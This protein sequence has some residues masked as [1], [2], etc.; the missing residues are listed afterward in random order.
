MATLA[1][2]LRAGYQPPKESALGDPIVQHFRDLPENLEKNQRAMDK[3]MG[4]MYKTDWMGKPNPNYYPEA[5][6]EFTQNYMPNLM[7]VHVPHTP[8]K[9]GLDVGKR[10][11]TE[12][13]GNLA[14][15]AKLKFEDL[16]GSS[17]LIMPWDSTSRNIAIKEI[18]GEKLPRQVVTHGGQDY[19][20]DLAHQAEGVV[21]ASNLG[22]AKRI[23]DR[24][25]MA[26]IE[27]ERMGGTGQVI[28][29]PTTMGAGAENFSV[30]PTEALLSLV[31]LRNP[32]KSFY[33][34]MNNAIR[35]TSPEGKPLSFKP[36]KGFAGID[37]EIGR[38][39]LYNG[40]GIDSTAGELRKAL[41]KALSKKSQGYNGGNTQQY[42]NYNHEDLVNA[43]T[44]PDLLGVGKG[45][46]GNTII[47]V[48]PEGMH[49][50]PSQNPT[51]NTNFT[52]Q[53]LGTLGENVPVE[54]IFPKTFRNLEQEFAGK[55][56]S[57][58]NNVLGA[59]EKRKMGVS[60]F[61]DDE[62]IDNY[63]KYLQD[64]KRQLE[65]E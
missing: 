18:S 48:G 58:R 46:V 11:V 7:G 62:A 49:L 15:K 28:H 24:D 8:L 31:D 56:G 14:D 9:P 39:Q 40:E 12:E 57:M 25:A 29:L 21:G 41:V 53:Y 33:D 47:G 2:L 38:M 4:G 36:F 44:D 13:L 34:Q 43:L 1:D 27:N 55:T 59:M 16:K 5:M 37:S 51:Y 61:I 30:M 10:Y 54:A 3:T 35:N 6:G 64:R 65:Q 42:L 23:K 32:S 63:Y 45:H 17:A 26:R 20:R 19:A 60:E 50:K 22:I 52:G